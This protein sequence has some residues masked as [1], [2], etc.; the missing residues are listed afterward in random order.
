MSEKGLQVISEA[1]VAVPLRDGTILRADIARPAASGRYPVMLQRTPYDKRRM[2]TFLAPDVAASRGYVVTNQ[3]TRGRFASEDEFFPYH[4]DEKDGYYTV[5]WAA[6]QPWSAE[7]VGM[8]GGSYMG[9]TQ[10]LA[11][12][13]TASA[14]MLSCKSRDR[15]YLMTAPI[16]LASSY[17]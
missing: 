12:M 1:N 3:D 9:G 14:M 15:P 13:A 7:K 17:R 16:L 2:A 5:E 11:A 10:Y 8:Y 4:D 6:A